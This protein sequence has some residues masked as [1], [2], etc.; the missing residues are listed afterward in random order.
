MQRHPCTRA[1]VD[2]NAQL[3]RRMLSFDF[4]TMSLFL[5]YL[6]ILSS[7]LKDSTR[8]F[9]IPW[10][11]SVGPFSPQDKRA[12]H[13]HHLV[14]K[15][16]I[17]LGHTYFSQL[18]SLRNRLGRSWGR[19]LPLPKP[20]GGSERWLVL[21][22]LWVSTFHRPSGDTPW[23]LVF[24]THSWEAFNCWSQGLTASRG[25]WAGFPEAWAWW[26]SGGTRGCPLQKEA[27]RVGRAGSMGPRW[28]PSSGLLA[29]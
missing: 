18:F 9:L 20:Q 22:W 15:Y 7:I 5:D 17:F 1:F 27:P 23:Q 14:N 3:Y 12:I 11:H 24:A 6:K 28:G 2:T 29:L 16:H 13:Q 26:V 8:L 19:W 21:A 4:S 25:A 10:S